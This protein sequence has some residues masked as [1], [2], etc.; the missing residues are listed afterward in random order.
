M[1][2]LKR[3]LLNS[4]MDK[5]FYRGDSMTFFVY[6]SHLTDKEQAIMTD[7]LKYRVLTTY[8]IRDKHFGGKGGYV[9]NVLMRLRKDGYIRTNTLKRSRKGKKGYSYHQLTETGKECLER[10]GVSV[11]GQSDRIYVSAHQVANLLLANET[12][13]EF[14]KLGWG[15][16]DSRTVKR[17][18]NLDYRDHIHGMVISPN[19]EEYGVYTLETSIS[20]NVIGRIQSEIQ[21]NK[22]MIKNYMIIAK[23]QDSYMLFIDYGIV[24]EQKS[25]RP[26]KRRTRK[27]LLTNGELIIEPFGN[28]FSKLNAFPNRRSWI[29]AL[30]RHYG[31][32]LKSTEIQQGARQS[33]PTIVEYGEQEYYLVDL[34]NH[35]LNLL[36]DVVAY[37][38]SHSSRRWEKR[39][40]IIV[41]LDVN[42]KLKKMVS[43]L[44]SPIKKVL[45]ASTFYEIIDLHHQSKTSM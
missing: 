4:R 16:L 29:E 19:G 7:L 11:E 18:Y 39:E 15:V 13:L 31:F 43:K 30:C 12:L 21:R 10:H 2:K 36:N 14:D 40:L 3:L 33:F 25:N 8:Q 22:E 6:D 17:K 28:I 38:S 45:N 5:Q 9:D 41:V 35:D 1:D 27:P 32:K 26:N 44:P 20:R 24:E 23:G 34:T 37:N 42:T